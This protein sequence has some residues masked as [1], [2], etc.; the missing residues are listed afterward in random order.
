MQLGSE[1]GQQH[2]ARCNR[3]LN[4]PAVYRDRL[5]FHQACWEQGAHQL[6]DAH[7]MVE[8]VRR[9]HDVSPPMVF[10]PRHDSLTP[11]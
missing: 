5:W 9:M 3:P 2:C 7:K 4:V 8:A 10:L 6:A 1:V 11:P